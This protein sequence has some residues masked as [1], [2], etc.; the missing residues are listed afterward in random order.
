MRL[1]LAFIYLINHVFY[2]VKDFF[3]H[4]Y[5]NTFFI[6]RGWVLGLREMTKKAALP[7]RAVVVWLAV[8][9]LFVV[10]A[11]WGLLPVYLVMRIFI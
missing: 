2:R 11:V 9:T 6:F 5:G 8:I 10:Y 4:W 3:V 1:D 7:V